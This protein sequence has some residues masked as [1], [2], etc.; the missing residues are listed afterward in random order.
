[1]HALEGR[2]DLVAEIKSSWRTNS[3]PVIT[4]HTRNED[5][6]HPARLT[7]LGELTSFEP[8][9]VNP[10]LRRADQVLAR[11]MEEAVVFERQIRFRLPAHE[12]EILR[13]FDL[14]DG[15]FRDAGFRGDGLVGITTAFREAIRNAEIHGCRQNGGR[16]IEVEL[17]LDKEKLTAS[18]ED[19]G[20]GFD[21]DTFR[22]GIRISAPI[23]IAR[24]RHRSGRAGGLGIYLME[25]CT[26]RVE[27]NDRGTR[28]TLTKLRGDGRE[29]ERKR[30]V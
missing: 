4:M 25:R 26:D 17:L 3:I 10:F 19:E 28:V 24:R 12:E 27:Y 18:V 22:D 5:L 6:K 15:F 9:E 7:V 23:S 13:G 30:A 11:V 1:D 2:D 21:H 20:Q 8:I 14:A 16:A 29:G